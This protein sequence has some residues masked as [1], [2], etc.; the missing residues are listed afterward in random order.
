MKFDRSVRGSFSDDILGLIF[1]LVG[2]LIFSGTLPATRIAVG[3]FDPWFLTFARAALATLAAIIVLISLKRSWPVRHFPMLFI[4]GLLLVY[5]FPGFMA[6]A[7][8]TLPSS[9]GGVVLGILPLATAIFATLLAG[10]RPSILFWIYGIIGAALITL[11]ALNDGSAPSQEWHVQSG[12]F[13]LLA[14]GL[15]ASSGYV[16][17]GKLTHHMPGWEV[18]SW[19]LLL[20]APLSFFGTWWLWQSSYASAPTSH[21]AAYIYLGLGSMYLGFFA[22]NTGLKLGGMARVGQL[23]LLQTFFTLGI[24]ALFLGEVIT[25]RTLLFAFGVFIVVLAGRRSQVIRK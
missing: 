24:S 9:H 2:V 6:V 12:D 14:A 15:C 17:S 4:S 19:A 22:W 21:I 8:V 16:M 7:M 20:T 23:Q 1:G 13:W 5:G 3:T 18:I 10:E 11:F 25:M